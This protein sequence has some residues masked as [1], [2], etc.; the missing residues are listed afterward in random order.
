MRVVVIGSGLLGLATSYFLRRMSIDVVILDSAPGAA[1]GTSFANGGLLTSGMAEPWNAPG[2]VHH[3]M[4]SIGRPDSPLLLQAR[5]LPAMIGWG[6]RFLGESRQHRYDINTLKNVRLALFSERALDELQSDVDIPC[7]FA[8]TGSLKLFRDSRALESGYRRATW[9]QQHGIPA[10]RL[11]AKQAV[12]ME[13]SL[14]DI[15]ERLAGAIYYPKD[16][17]G[18]ARQFCEG[19]VDV[20]RDQGVEINFNTSVHGW[21]RR[22]ERIE[23][24]ITTKGKFVADAYV[25]AAAN[26]TRS[27]TKPIGFDVPI[28]PAKG[29]SISVPSAA[30]AAAPR[31]PVIDDE[32]HAVVVPLGESLRVAGTAEFAGMD[33]TISAPRIENLLHLLHD[34]YPRA[35]AGSSTLALNPWAGL[36]PLSADGV[37]ILGR[38]PFENLY[39]NTGHGHL[40]WTLAA[41][42]GKA[43]AQ[44]VNGQEPELDMSDYSLSRFQRINPASSN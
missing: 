8:R 11:D 38:T 21:K 17:S 25:V 1:R 5:A 9:V 18:D 7:H 6:L 29:Y 3:L 19:L 33:D 39:L 35:Q 26:A 20:L 36:R 16:C 37:P 28:R 30:L 24:A 41:G 42:S 14:G 22:G 34:I 27:L 13:P 23:A 43:V 32:L 31:L 44:I 15:S 4:K 2:V 12:S 10:Q 40:G